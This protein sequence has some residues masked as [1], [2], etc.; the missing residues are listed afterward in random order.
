MLK[1]RREQMATFSADMA[2]RFESRLVARVEEHFPEDHAEQ[3]DDGVRQTI[4]AGVALAHDYGIRAERDVARFVLLLYELGPDF[5][6]SPRYPWAP[7]VL[8]RKGASGTE[9]MDLLCDLAA[10]KAGAR[11]LE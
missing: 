7:G 6:V 5:D 10:E 8:A 9:K 1:I 11:R 3:G 2:E 4:R